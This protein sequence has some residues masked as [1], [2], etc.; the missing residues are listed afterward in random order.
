MAALPEV[1]GL[2]WRWMARRYIVIRFYRVLSLVSLVGMVPLHGLTGLSLPGA[3]HAAVSTCG[4]PIAV[5]GA[6]LTPE[7]R[8]QVERALGVGPSTRVLRETVADEGSTADDLVPPALLGRYAISSVL[9]RLL[10]PGA[11]LHVAL[12][13]N[14]TLYPARSYANALLTAGV[15]SA[16]VSIAAPSTQRALGTTALLSL[17]RAVRI[18]CIAAT[19]TPARQH[20]AIREFMLTHDLATDMGYTQ[21]PRLMA[22]LKAATATGDRSRTAL[23]ARAQQ[24]AATL[25]L[26]IASSLQAPLITFLQDLARS[27]AYAGV[28]RAHPS[29]HDAPPTRTSVALARPAHGGLARG[30]VVAFG[31]GTL[32]VRQRDGIHT[33]QLA[34]NAPIVSA[35][36]PSS[37]AALVPGATVSVAY[38]KG[39]V[40][41]RLEVAPAGTPQAPVAGGTIQGTLTR[42][43]AGAAAFSLGTA[44]GA[45]NVSPAPGVQ[46]SRDGRPSSISALQAGDRLDVTTNAQGQAT[47]IAASSTP[48]PASTPIFSSNR[49]GL[50][51]SALGL[52]LLLLLLALL[53][54]LRRRR[55]HGERHLAAAAVPDDDDDPAEDDTPEVAARVGVAAGM[56]G[57]FAALLGKLHRPREVS[58]SARAA[59]AEAVGTCFLTLAALTGH[60]P[61]AVALTL[62]AFVYALSDISGCH[63]NPAVTLGLASARRLPVLTALMYIVAQLAGALLA[64]LLAPQVAPLAAHYASGTA[65]G[66]FLGF[67]FL[68]LTV[69]AVSDK[70]VPRSGSGVAIGA[71]LL[72]G[73]LASGGIV[74]P[75]IAVAM[76]Q[77]LSPAGWAPL[78][79]GIAFTGLFLLVAPRKQPDAT[80]V[81]EE[82][83]EQSEQRTRRTA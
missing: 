3:A 36:A 15:T 8:L 44:G 81:Q 52:G 25:G 83:P 71:A 42:T 2:G 50:L 72:A 17:L 38:G 46:V 39:S 11:G 69:I 55:R 61:V 53:L 7:G 49:A 1:G 20:L 68:M 67:G 26:P 22:T 35:G 4:T 31:A 14:V 74:N 37:S 30:T 54:F 19:V 29:I 9:L 32:S 59:L 10:P 70:Y 24:T 45:V 60:T 73:L 16:E 40:A 6:D 57:A 62:A 41:Q 28:A 21:A 47:R 56:G 79:S 80:P 23:T 33:Y 58:D 43:A 18:S 65:V 27:G 12:N 76:G 5:L 66:E 64:R 77:G 13:P 51:A 48:I 63:L 78:L 82:Q 34:P 75:A